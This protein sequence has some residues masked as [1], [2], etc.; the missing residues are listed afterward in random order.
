MIGAN[1]SVLWNFQMFNISNNSLCLY[2][3]KA[4]EDTNTGVLP[5]NFQRMEQI[6]DL[7]FLCLVLLCEEA[8]YLLANNAKIIDRIAFAN[9]LR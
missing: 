4:L 6:I 8:C 2:K 3:S 1:V 5:S 9:C 7:H